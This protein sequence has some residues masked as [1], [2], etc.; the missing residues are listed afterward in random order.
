VIN[1][2]TI[3]LIQFRF[4]A[5]PGVSSTLSWDTQTAGACEYTDGNGA[6]ITS[7]YTASNISTVANA[8]MVSAGPDKAKTGASVQLEGLATGGVTPYTYA[9][10]PTASLNNPAIATPLASPTVTT[11]YTLTVTGSNACSGSDV[12]VVTVNAIPNDLTVQNVTVPNGTTNCYNAYQTISVAG[13]GTYFLVQSGGSATFIAGLKISYFPGTTVQSGGYMRGYITTNGL[14]CNNQTT[15][16]VATT[17]EDTPAIQNPDD[18]FTVYPNP[19]A[20]SFTIRMNDHKKFQHSRIV[21]YGNLGESI[22][23]SRDD[24]FT[25]REFSLDGKPAGIYF[26]SVTNGN[27]HQIRKIVKL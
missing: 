6:I 22:F 16:M 26:I 12:M 27:D 2:G 3:T 1:A 13:S 7:F 20:G 23:D 5:D 4:I 18:L 15:P 19:T 10:S 25:S 8:L 11:T 17:V 9:W 14:Y 21:I 24:V